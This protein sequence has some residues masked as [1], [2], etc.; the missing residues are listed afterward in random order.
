MWQPVALR[1]SITFHYSKQILDDFICKEFQL[2]H[3][4]MYSDI[5]ICIVK[6]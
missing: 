2:T 1:L 3:I 6:F 4:F 5:H